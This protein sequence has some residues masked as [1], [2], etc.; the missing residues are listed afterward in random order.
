M[1]WL[2][3]SLALPHRFAPGDAGL[4]KQAAVAATGTPRGVS[5]CLEPHILL[6]EHFSKMISNRGRRERRIAPL[7]LVA[8]HRLALAENGGG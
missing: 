6:I 2:S 1:Y 8:S 3:V 5:V 7:L 4:Q